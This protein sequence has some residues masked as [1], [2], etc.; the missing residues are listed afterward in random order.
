MKVVDRNRDAG[1]VAAYPTA[2]G[3]T[4]WLGQKIGH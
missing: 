3:A 1:N 2:F 4:A